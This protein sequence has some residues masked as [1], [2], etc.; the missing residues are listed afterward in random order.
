MNICTY[1]EAAVKPD[2]Y[3]TLKFGTWSYRVRPFFPSSKQL[4][5]RIFAANY[6][7]ANVSEVRIN[8]IICS[9]PT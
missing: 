1:C 9:Y 2:E 7:F 6:I 4:L 8:L 3:V 5:L